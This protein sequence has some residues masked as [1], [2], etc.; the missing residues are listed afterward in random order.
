MI[1]IKIIVIVLNI[2][3]I[4]DD[5]IYNCGRRRR[6]EGREMGGSRGHLG[7]PQRCA[8]EGGGGGTQKNGAKKGG[9]PKG[10]GPKG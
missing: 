5:N 2:I 8:P 3:K 1:V 4:N 9:A 6:G 7:G 10:G